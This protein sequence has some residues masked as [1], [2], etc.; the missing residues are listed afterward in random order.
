MTLESIRALVAKLKETGVSIGDTKEV[1]I[2]SVLKFRI[3]LYIYKWLLTLSEP[4][5][6][7]LRSF[8]SLFLILWD[9]WPIKEQDL[10]RL[11]LV[12]V[13]NLRNKVEQV[14]DRRLGSLWCVSLLH[15]SNP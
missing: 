3:E 10:S 15:I 8:Q 13:S 5:R 6:L 2:I 1:K 12:F 4:L 7:I 14:R 11:I 9:Y